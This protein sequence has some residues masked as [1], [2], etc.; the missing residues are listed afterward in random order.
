MALFA[1]PFLSLASGQFILGAQLLSPLQPP[2]HTNVHAQFFLL[3]YSRSIRGFRKVWLPP[4]YLQA[5]VY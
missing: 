4:S 3:G 1:L 2:A 5:G